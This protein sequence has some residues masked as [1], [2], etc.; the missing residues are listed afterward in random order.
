MGQAMNRT[1]SR[2]PSGGQEIFRMAIRE[3]RDAPIPRPVEIHENELNGHLNRLQYQGIIKCSAKYIVKLK[4][5]LLS[6]KRPQSF[7]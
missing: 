1:P 2:R 7:Q 5:I 3:A 4:L 6:N